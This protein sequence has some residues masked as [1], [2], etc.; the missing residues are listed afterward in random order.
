M[1][2]P[3]LPAFVSLFVALLIGAVPTHACEPVCGTGG[4]TVFLGSHAHTGHDRGVC[5]HAEHAAPHRHVHRHEAADDSCPSHDHGTP[6]DGEECCNDGPGHSLSL[7]SRVVMPSVDSAPVAAPVAIPSGLPADGALA[8]VFSVPIASGPP[9][10][11]ESV[12][13]LR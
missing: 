8:A 10:G 7:V 2:L 4:G 3:S 1:R 13:L 6:A 12:V 9:A 11:I 5:G